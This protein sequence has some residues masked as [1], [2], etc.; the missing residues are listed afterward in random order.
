MPTPQFSEIGDNPT[1]QQIQNY[2]IK[3]Q[4]DLQWLLQNLDDLNISRLN[5]KVIIANTISADKLDVEKLSAI[6]ADLGEINA[7]IIRGI[8]IYGSLIATNETG[9][10]R[11]EMSTQ[12]NYFKVW[13]NATNYLEIVDAGDEGLP[14]I[15]FV[16]GNK[17]VKMGH[18]VDNH[19]YPGIVS[20]DPFVMF[21]WGGL[22]L[23]GANIVESWSDLIRNS[24]GKTLEQELDGLRS[25]INSLNTS[26]S[27]LTGVINDKANKSV[28]TSSA[29]GHNHGISDGTVLMKYDGS[30]VTYYNYSGHSHTQN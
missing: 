9:Y 8:E 24:D 20:S 29:G 6:S 4:R 1:P 11:T 2:L 18:G 23:A 21:A 15:V 7:G 19:P 17:R 28:S 25:S 3:L 27:T 26:I 14:Q 13:L 30:P 10:P 22:Y 12:D 16:S 5:A